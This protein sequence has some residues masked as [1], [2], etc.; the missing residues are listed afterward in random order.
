MSVRIFPPDLF[1][2]KP[3]PAKAADVLD[4]MADERREW[5][6]RMRAALAHLYELRAAKWG[7]TQAVY[8]CADDADRLAKARPDLALPV[9]ASPNLMGSV[10][11]T[12][13]W[14]AIDR[15]HVSSQPGSHGNLLT[16]W[17]YVGP[18]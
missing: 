15:S 16:R 7:A 8:V 13:E 5:L 10:F 18:R 2:A 6:D 1:D 9:G 3:E 17:R 14:R 12:A 4:R 11:R